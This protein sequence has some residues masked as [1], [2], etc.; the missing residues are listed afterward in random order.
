MIKAAPIFLGLA[1]LVF[2]S[3]TAP[4]QD[5][6]AINAADTEAVMRQANTIVLRL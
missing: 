6:S 1:A 5:N 4:A 3:G 2:F